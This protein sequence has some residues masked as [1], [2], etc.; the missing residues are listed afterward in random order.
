MRKNPSS[1]GIDEFSTSIHDLN[2]AEKGIDQLQITTSINKYT[3]LHKIERHIEFAIK[4]LFSAVD[5]NHS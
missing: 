3:R 5:L 1:L 2:G 4:I